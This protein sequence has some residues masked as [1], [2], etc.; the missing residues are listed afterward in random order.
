MSDYMNDAIRRA[1]RRGTP[2]PSDEPEQPIATDFDSGPRETP[3]TSPTMSARIRESFGR[4]RASGRMSID[5][6]FFH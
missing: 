3:P 5:D 6:V 1:A 4:M 2:S